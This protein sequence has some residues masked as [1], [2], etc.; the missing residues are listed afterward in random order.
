[1]TDR[2]VH[3]VSMRE[4]RKPLSPAHS[5]RLP[6]RGR[7]GCSLQA[8]HR[9][10]NS[11]HQ[12]SVQ[13]DPRNLLRQAQRQMIRRSY[14]CTQGRAGR[15]M[16]THHPRGPAWPDAGCQYRARRRAACRWRAFHRVAH[17]CQYQSKRRI[18]RDA[19]SELK[20]K[21]IAIGAVLQAVTV[22]ISR[23]K[24]GCV[25]GSQ[26]LGTRVRDQCHLATQHVDE[27]V[28]SGVPVALARPCSGR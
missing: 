4:R 6:P 19:C 1:M 15:V 11:T 14:D 12:E 21:R 10:P 13:M 17:P 3:A 9:H 18:T 5:L 7:Q 20:D 26:Y 23:L 24:S 2:A 16:P 25:P 22:R 8:T 27:F 28:G